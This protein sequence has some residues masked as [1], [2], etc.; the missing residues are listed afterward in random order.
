MPSAASSEASFGTAEPAHLIRHLQASKAIG[1]QRVT[2]NAAAS[3]VAESTN[4]MR[5]SKGSQSKSAKSDGMR[6]S[7]GSKSA[8]C[9]PNAYEAGRGSAP[10]DDDCSLCCLCEEFMNFPSYQ[11]CGAGGIAYPNCVLPQVAA[12]FGGSE[13]GWAV[14]QQAASARMMSL[15]SEIGRNFKYGSMHGCWLFSLF[16]PSAASS[17]AS[18][19]TAKHRS[20]L[21]ATSPG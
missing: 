5:R 18:F 8:T 13:R 17:E 9:I 6:R 2:T 1:N 19:G 14:Q 20:S 12:Y 10:P 11:R 15:V 21:F 16:M 7:K 4:G 3:F